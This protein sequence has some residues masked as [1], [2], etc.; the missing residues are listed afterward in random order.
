M[1]TGLFI[2]LPGSYPVAELHCAQKD[3]LTHDSRIFYCDESFKYSH[4]NPFG[5]SAISKYGI[6]RAVDVAKLLEI[7]PTVI[8]YSDL[9]SNIDTFIDVDSAERIE[10]GV[11]SSIASIT[12][13]SSRFELESPWD[14][15][16]L[17]MLNYSK[18]LFLY[19]K[20]E[21]ENG[22]DQIY[23]FNGRFAEDCA[24]RTAAIATG[25]SY[26][27]YDFKKAGTY[28]IFNNISLHSVQENHRRALKY[29]CDN[30]AR[31]SE[32]ARE[33]VQSKIDG[34]ATYERSYTEL[35]QKNKITVAIDNMKK[36]ISIFPSS[37]D[38]YRF[39]SGGEWGAPIVDSQIEEIWNLVQNVDEKKYQVIVRMHPNMYG[40]S[41]KIIHQY[42]LIERVF[43]HCSV[44]LPEDSSSTYTLIDKSYCVICFCSTVSVE[45][46]YLRKYVINIGGT[47]YYNLPISNYVDSG[48][49]AASLIN[50]NKLKNKSRRASIIWMNYLW[51][52]SDK[53]QY[54]NSSEIK[55]ADRGKE[56][57]IKVVKPYWSRLF[58]A[59]FRAEIQLRLPGKK[60]IQYFVRL[61]KSILD[62]LFNK[63]SIKN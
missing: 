8:Q 2:S 45:A 52:Y 1:N 39:L 43:E 53:N 41:K 3:S 42:L 44:L 62:I 46:N 18:E 12:R 25:K 60:N 19:F 4:L 56:F 58:Q 34:I 36:I 27:V 29:Y 38:E 48:V 17:N 6:K 31:A 14:D 32:V 40:L 10:N 63:F 30:P 5:R 57:R 55:M 21:F 54:I 13:V 16:Y 49:N 61:Y 7:S 33:F 9:Q 35:Q 24:V 47:P 50:N 11:M 22:L 15:V 20:S 59:P 26:I 23:L 51:K 28:Y 37:D